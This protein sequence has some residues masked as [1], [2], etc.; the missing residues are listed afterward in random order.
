MEIFKDITFDETDF[1]VGNMGTVFR[2]GAPANIVVTPD[3]YLQVACKTRSIGI[4]RL[5]AMCFVEGRSSE[6]NEVNHKDFDRTNNCAD[7]LEWMSH[8]DNIRYSAKF[9]RPKNIFGENNPNWGNTKLSEFYSDNPEI[10]K[11]K[12]GRPGNR[13]GKAKPVDVYQGDVFVGHFDYI[14]QCWEYM[15]DHYSFAGTAETMR[16]GIRRAKKR[17]RPYKGFTFIT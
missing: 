4:H 2:N 17:G 11:I 8:A 12:Q 9:G 15:R 10:A 14:G 5:V 1:K 7:N 6:A 16:L 13:N 3:G